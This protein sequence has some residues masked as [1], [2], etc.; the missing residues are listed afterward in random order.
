M[1]QG[2]GKTVIGIGLV[3]FF[4]IIMFYVLKGVWAVMSLLA[5]GFLLVALVV[6]YRVVIDYVKRLLDLLKRNPLYGV[7]GIIFSVVLYP[8]VFLVLMLRALGGKAFA[9]VG[10]STNQKEEEEFTDYEILDDEPLDLKEIHKRKM[11]R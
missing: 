2:I 3:A 5:W 10:F 11:E 7:G 6:N 9:N 8:L 4:A 1:K